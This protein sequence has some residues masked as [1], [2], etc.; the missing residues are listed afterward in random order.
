MADTNIP[1]T[2]GYVELPD[3]KS[4]EIKTRRRAYGHSVDHDAGVAYINVKEEE[5]YVDG[6]EIIVL[7]TKKGS[8]SVDH[9]SVIGDTDL[10]AKIEA[11]Y[12]L[13][14]NKESFKEHISAIF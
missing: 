3:T 1:L 6:E 13:E 2:D 4:V 7:S 9:A 10:R 14:L 5:Y 12:Q 11:L 8:V